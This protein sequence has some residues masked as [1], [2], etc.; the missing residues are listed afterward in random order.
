MRPG[1]TDTLRHRLTA[2]AALAL[3]LLS[4]WQLEGARRGIDVT[5]LAIGDTPVTR[6]SGAAPGP[7]VVIAHGFAGSREMMQ[8]YALDLARAGYTAYTF[9]FLGHGAHTRPMSGDVTAEDGTTRRLVDQTKSVIEATRTDTPTALLGHSMA[10]D[11]LVRV[12]AETEGTGPLVLLS[13]F[14]REITPQAPP[15]L[16]LITGAWEPGLTDFA[17]RTVAD[18]APDTRRAAIIAPRSDH[19]SI[20]QSVV[21][22]QAAV[23]WLNDSY[24]RAAP[25]HIP[26]T[27]W[28]LI[29]LLA[30]I[31]ALTPTLARAL[32]RH[33]VPAAPLRPVPFLAVALL[34]AI[35]APLI[36]VPLDIAVLPVLVADYL[37]L[38]LALLGALQL[39][40]LWRFGLRPGGLSLA[41]LL[42]ILVWG[43]GAF[44]LALDRYGANFVPNGGRLWIIAALCVGTVPFMLADALLSGAGHGPLWQRMTARAAFLGSLALAVALDF[45]G[46][47]F[48]ILIAPVIVLFY[49]VFG[50]MGRWVAQRSGATSAGLGLGLLL[51]WALGVSFPLFA[52]GG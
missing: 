39:L 49:I 3:I 41:A 9:D 42:L 43:L 20:L 38:H 8:G 29:G 25:T 51:A 2:L 52:A 26:A 6:Y 21:A 12:A 24:G 46:L 47:F 31:V 33:A 16:I 28:G 13:A 14:S 4:L 35:A 36:A 23:D 50:L 34:P 22:R 17:R 5:H 27:G 1:L 40:L 7:V 10:T 48:L 19:V 15:D 30:G 32:P 45:S 18:T 37:A 44:G 11:V